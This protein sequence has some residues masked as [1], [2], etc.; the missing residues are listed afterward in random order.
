MTTYQF[1]AVTNDGKTR[2]GTHTAENEK[3]VA[4]ELRRQGLTPIY[5]GLGKSGGFELKLPEWG[6]GKRRDVL[7]F[8]QEISTLLNSSVPIDRALTIV[9]ELTEKPAFRAV[10][11][12]ILRLIKG[13]KTLA[14]A[15]GTH[16]T[17]FSDLYVNM[18]RAGE[19][20]GSLSVV[21]QRLS[22]F[23]RNR[24]ELR[25]YIISS[26]MY[27]LLLAITG[28]G[29]IVVL[30]YFVVPKFA[31]IFEGGRMTIPLPTLVM[32]R[33][34]EFL[35]AWG[36]LIGLGLI[37]FGV[38]FASFIRTE[39]GRW[40]WDEFRLRVPLLGDA[41]RKAETARFARAMA[42]LVSNTVPLVQS[43]QIAGG[44]LA[45]QR[46]ARALDSVAQ[47]V[48]RGEGIAVPLRR[49]G[50]FP[51]LASHLLS[52]GEETGKLDEMFTRMA[53]IYENDTRD[54][55]KRFTS[56]FEPLLILTMGIVV[57]ALILSMLLAITSIN[58]VA[59]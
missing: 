2:T 3:K 48:K 6:A 23:E 8:T 18:V 45:N 10:V 22:H 46:I 50:Q 19:A 59:I 1:R 15:L 20:S 31:T 17:Y 47:G 32:L 43:I 56:L 44:T 55:I 14:D 11:I 13:G 53:D 5:I 16:G 51:S 57:G 21:F 29:A 24:D 7:F 28:V 41:L 54:A 33:T 30:M 38:G 9:S 42:T 26:M 34:S 4:A 12:D 27:P 36:W 37:A 35:Q 25:G 49:C 52:V 40:W 39:K 58:E